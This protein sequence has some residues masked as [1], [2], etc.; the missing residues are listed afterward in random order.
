MPA[1]VMLE[2]PTTPPLSLV[3]G[4][5]VAA[6]LGRVLARIT[7]H[8]LREVLEFARRG[9][10]PATEA[11][12]ARARNAII[13]VSPRCRGQWCLQ[14]AIATAL[15]CR[16][17]GAWPQ[18]CTGVR[19]E[20]FQAHAWVAVDGRPVGEPGSDIGYFQ[21]MMAVPPLGRDAS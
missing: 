16:A 11:E 9:A 5:V 14:R 2:R 20:P 15:L 12:A 1:G 19:T 4:A 6:G 3:P 13:A 18:W 21:V 10:R 17:G 8:R 7:P